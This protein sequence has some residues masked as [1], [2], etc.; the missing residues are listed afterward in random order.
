MLEMLTGPVSGFI[1]IPRPIIYSLKTKVA[2]FKG[3]CAELI[4]CSTSLSVPPFPLQLLR[5][6]L[7]PGFAD[8]P[9]PQPL[10]T[11]GRGVAGRE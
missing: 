8:C 1:L 3:A 11:Q 5:A 2:C 7:L 10:G 9:S 6:L 4:C